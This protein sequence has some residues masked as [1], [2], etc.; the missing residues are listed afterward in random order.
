MSLRLA[1][2][3]EHTQTQRAS[4]ERFTSDLLNSLLNVLSLTVDDMLSPEPITPQFTKCYTAFISIS[5]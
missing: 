5:F 1:A 3:Q 2:L 4:I